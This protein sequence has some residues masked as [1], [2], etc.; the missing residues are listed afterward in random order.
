MNVWTNCRP[1]K[2]T[3]KHLV[4]ELILQA[5]RGQSSPS[6]RLSQRCAETGH[7]WRKLTASWWSLLSMLPQPLACSSGSIFAN[8]LMATHWFSP[9]VYV[10]TDRPGIVGERRLEAI[11]SWR[12]MR[13][14]ASRCPIPTT[15]ILQTFLTV[16]A[17]RRTNLYNSYM[18]LMPL[19]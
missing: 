13:V 9:A 8:S 17:Q 3:A 10:R 11:G 12:S 15:E 5:R 16:A 19:R 4:H 2:V 1:D 14:F 7:I 18:A 6:K